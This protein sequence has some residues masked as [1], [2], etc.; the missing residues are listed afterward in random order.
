MPEDPYDRGQAYPARFYMAL[1]QQRRLGWLEI[2]WPLDT[3]DP[4]A[5]RAKLSEKT[6]V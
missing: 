3:R 6:P 1:G 4:N 5:A 2:A